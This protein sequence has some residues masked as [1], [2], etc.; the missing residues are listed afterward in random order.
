VCE[1]EILRLE[2]EVQG[3]QSAFRKQEEEGR[4]D[5]SLQSWKASRKADNW[6]WIKEALSLE[7][8]EKHRHDALHEA[9]EELNPSPGRSRSFLYPLSE[10]EFAAAA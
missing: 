9:E 2:E 8:E 10:E 1:K 4:V 3:R 5:V 7:N 6:W